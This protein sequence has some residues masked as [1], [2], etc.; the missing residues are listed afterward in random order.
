MRPLNKLEE[1]IGY[2]FIRKELLLLS[3]THSSYANEHGTE[4]NERLEYL[5]DAVLELAMS[6]YLYDKLHLDEGVLSKTRA[7]AV[8]EE[9]LNVY[10]DKIEE[11]KTICWCGRKA[12]MVA[13]VVGGKFVRTGE[14]IEI[15]GNDMY[16]SLCRKHYNDGRISGD[17]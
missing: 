12:T 7:K 2:S 13:K 6:R 1:K 9:A 3:L 16:V 14:Q 4:C 10:A 8:C 5:G 17:K 11:I 15:G